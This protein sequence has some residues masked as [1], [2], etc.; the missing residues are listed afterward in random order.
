MK[1]DLSRAEFLRRMALLSGGVGIGISG[2]PGQAYAQ[3][4]AGL[5]ASVPTGNAVVI[6]QLSGGN[7]GLNT[8]IPISAYTDYQTLR[9]NIHIPSSV[10]LPLNTTGKLM[11]NTMKQCLLG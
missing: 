6:I 2:I 10:Y 3:L 4:P 5:A 7:D 8:V 11:K 1:K 9:P